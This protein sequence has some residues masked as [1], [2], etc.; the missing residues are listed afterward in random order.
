MLSLRAML[1]TAEHDSVRSVAHATGAPTASVAE[2][3][4][5]GAIGA[6]YVRTGGLRG[7]LGLGLNDVGFDTAGA[8]SRQYAGGSI[9]IQGNTPKGRSETV[10][11]VRY[12]GFHCNAE[13][14]ESSASDEPYFIVSVASSQGSKTRTFGVY[15]NVDAG[16]DVSAADLLVSE[17][18]GLT[19]PIVLGVVGMENDEGTPAEAEAKVRAIFEAV[20]QKI[21]EAA[22]ALGAFNGENHVMPEWMRDIIIGWGPEFVADIFGLADDLINTESLVIFD[23]DANLDSWRA[24]PIIGKHKGND[25]NYMIRINQQGEDEGDYTLFFHI[26]LFQVNTEILPKG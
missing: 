19:P 14:N 5:I 12:V 24:A 8:G 9:K 17:D 16:D 25:Y 21:D 15:E 11:R 1:D 10:V 2:Q 20:E 26:D 4:Q 22:S 3:V 18:D 6:Y 7:P 23:Y 13:S